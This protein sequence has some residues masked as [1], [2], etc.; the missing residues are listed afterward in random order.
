MGLPGF[1][2]T[3]LMDPRPCTRIR[4]RRRVSGKRE[5]RAVSEEGAAKGAR[6]DIGWRAG[7]GGG[8]GDDGAVEAENRTTSREVASYV[9]AAGLERVAALA[10]AGGPECARGASESRT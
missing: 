4:Y 2:E 10:V 8:A 7:G 3:E 9:K 5:G 1:W 6:E